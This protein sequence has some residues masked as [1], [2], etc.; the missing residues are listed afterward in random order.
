MLSTSWVGLGIK[1]K[2][3]VDVE[4]S[5]QWRG[6]KNGLF[7]VKAMCRALEKRSLSPCPWKGILMICAQPKVPFF[8]LG[9]IFGEVLNV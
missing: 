2:F 9:G 3:I 4:D 6:A 1:K 8:A 7:S 5:V